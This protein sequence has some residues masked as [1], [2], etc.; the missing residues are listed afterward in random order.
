MKSS[1]EP[2]AARA[3][4]PSEGAVSVE[5]LLERAIVALTALDAEEAERVA[6]DLTGPERLVLPGTAAER[7][8]IEE[9]RRVL[10]HLLGS[11]GRRLAM[12]QRVSAGEND[13]RGYGRGGS[14]PAL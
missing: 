2:T 4:W 1:G 10:G 12:V 6:G 3:S 13:W 8:R 14:S 7:R 9:K 11:T 5:V